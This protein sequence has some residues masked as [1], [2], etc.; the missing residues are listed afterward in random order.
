MKIVKDKKVYDLDWEATWKVCDLP[1]ALINELGHQ[2]E[3]HR[4][5]CRTK[6]VEDSKRTGDFFIL[7]TAEGS[8]YSRNAVRVTPVTPDEAVALAEDHVDY[9]TYV[10]FFGDPRGAEAES[11]E[12]VKAA[13]AGRRKAESNRDFW[14]K[15]HGK[16]EKER[17]ELKKKLEEIQAKLDELK[18]GEA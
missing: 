8:R 2:R 12:R 17:D 5:L 18:G 13:E 4:E 3:V 10:E 7:E 11:D 1:H 15:E 6:V 9:D 14:Y 16:V